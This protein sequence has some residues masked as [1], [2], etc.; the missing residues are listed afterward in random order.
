MV[1]AVADAKARFSELVE[2]ARQNGP[3]RITR[4]GKLVG[5]LVSP[6]DW[7]KQSQQEPSKNARTTSDFFKNSPLV[8]SGLV[9][10]R[11]RSKP[12]KVDL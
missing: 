3:Q 9:V 8:G 12:R 4:N 5:M 2:N 11:S 10:R 7:E 1:W 6:E